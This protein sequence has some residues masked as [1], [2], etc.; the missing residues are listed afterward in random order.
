MTGVHRDA[1]WKRSDRYGGSRVAGDLHPYEPR[2]W[3][4]ENSRI[5]PFQKSKGMGHPARPGNAILLNGGL[6]GGGFVFGWRRPVF[7]Q[8]RG[9]FVLR[10]NRAMKSI[11]IG[12]IA[13]LNTMSECFTPDLSGGSQPERNTN[14]PGLHEFGPRKK[15]GA[16]IESPDQNHRDA[17]GAHR[18]A[19][20]AQPGVA[21]LLETR[22]QQAAPLRTQNLSHGKF[23]KPILS[24]F[25]RVGF[26]NF[27]C[28]KFWVRRGAACLL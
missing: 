12:G 17:K 19:E 22:A 2:I 8:K 11:L 25:E 15:P 14:P 1:L 10:S 20:S 16:P 5:P 9:D 7:R 13:C 18:G 27:P 24:I 4:T 21:V 28:V 3:S 6:L 26:V 23:T